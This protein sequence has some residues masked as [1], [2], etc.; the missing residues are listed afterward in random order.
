M[1]AASGMRGTRRALAFLRALCRHTGGDGGACVKHAAQLMSEDSAV[2]RAGALL[3]D[4]GLWAL[5]RRGSDDLARLEE[6]YAGVLDFSVP[7]ARAFCELD[8]ALAVVDG[9]CASGHA[10]VGGESGTLDLM[11]GGDRAVLER[12]E[13]DYLSAVCYVVATLYG[14]TPLGALTG[15]S[16]S[17]VEDLEH[18]NAVADGILDAV[19]SSSELGCWIISRCQEGGTVLPPSRGYVFDWAPTSLS[20]LDRAHGLRRVAPFLSAARDSSSRVVLAGKGNV[21]G[22]D[23]LDSVRLRDAGVL[24]ALAPSALVG[25]DVS[26]IDPLRSLRT[27]LGGDAFCIAPAE[28][29]LALDRRAHQ[30]RKGMRS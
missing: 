23:P 24:T 11:T 27:A 25:A 26:L 30:G 10:V 9:S 13:R 12:L 4:G 22:T 29:A 2:E 16:V 3:A 19:A 7:A 18:V 20:S 17:S 28:L 15:V 21:V 6:A 1:S 14:T 8:A 5:T